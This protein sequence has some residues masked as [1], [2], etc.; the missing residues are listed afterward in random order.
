MGDLLLPNIMV[1]VGLAHRVTAACCGRMSQPG[2]I[3]TCTDIE[4][5]AFAADAQGLVCLL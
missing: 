4:H 2:T 1:V 5:H 3:G